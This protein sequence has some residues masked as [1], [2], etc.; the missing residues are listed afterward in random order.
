M[1]KTENEMSDKKYPATVVVHWA[2]GPV[3]CCEQHA[4]QL[5]ALG[6]M[7]GGHTPASKAK[8]GAECSNCINENKTA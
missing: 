6:N 5:V 8:E 3:D 1:Q 4:N 2:T 7:L